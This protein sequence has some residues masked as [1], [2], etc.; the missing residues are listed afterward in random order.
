MLAP[1]GD[2]ITNNAGKRV[3]MASS[4]CIKL[5]FFTSGRKMD[6]MSLSTALSQLDIVSTPF[7]AVDVVPAWS[8][9]G[10]SSGEA[11][12]LIVLRGRG[13]MTM[14]QSV[15]P[16]HAGQLWLISGALPPQLSSES[17][18]NEL[19]V[20]TGMLRV[21]LLDGRSMFDFIDTPHVYDATGT[22]LFTGAIPELLRESAHGGPGSDAIVICLIRRLVTVLVRDAWPETHQIPSGKISAQGQQFQK[23]VD[24]MS[25]DPARRYTLDNLASTAG[26]SRTV[27]HRTFSQTYGVSPLAMLKKFRLKRAE[28]LLRQTNLPIKT[29]ASRLGY[30]SR[31]YFWQSF[32]D[33]YGLDPERYRE[34]NAAE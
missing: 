24:L 29:I 2:L 11:M 8:P 3:C 16:M 9:L 31:S 12:L 21:S 25:K 5:A 22:E 27:F 23:I 13:S 7:N 20:A 19:A 10:A 14:G 34:N 4:A 30:Q 26:M 6:T 32:K 1:S 33:A 17:G 15:M 28:L 18:D